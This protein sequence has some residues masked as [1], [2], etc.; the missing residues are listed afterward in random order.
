[1]LAPDKDS[2]ANG[3]GDAIRL[4]LLQYAIVSASLH[5]N[6]FLLRYTPDLSD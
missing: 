1:M 4:T 6:N 3:G 2:P 5:M